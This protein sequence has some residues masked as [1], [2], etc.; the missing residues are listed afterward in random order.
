MFDLLTNPPTTLQPTFFFG[1]MQNL[2]SGQILLAPPALV[3]FDRAGKVPTSYAFNIGVQ[4]KLPLDSVLDVSYV[5]TLG[6]HLLQRRNI[7]APYYGAAFQTANQDPTAAFN[8]TGAS[9]LPVDPARR[10]RASATSPISSRPPV[11]TTILCRPR[12]IA[13]SRR[14]LLSGVT[15]NLEQGAR[16][17]GRRTCPA[18]TG[19]ARRASTP[20]TGRPTMARRIST[21]GTTSTS[22]GCMNSP[23]RRERRPRLAPER[24][25]AFGHLPLSDGRTV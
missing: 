11:R 20:T 19:S 1:T 3:A 10:T 14:A 24:L 12:G 4:K 13:A 21:A 22:T 5:G 25:A 17:A 2:N 8:A 15:R 9:A 6:A 23:G 18:S 16:H 7:N